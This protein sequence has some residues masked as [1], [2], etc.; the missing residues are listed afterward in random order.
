VNARSVVGRFLEHARVIAFRRGGEWEVWCGS[1]DGMPRSFE[2]RFELM[3]PVADPRARDH[4]LRELRSQLQDDVNAFE[5]GASGSEEPR[6]GGA[7]DCQRMPRHD[8]GPAAQAPEAA[9][10]PP[11]QLPE[12]APPLG[13]VGQ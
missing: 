9:G 6:W 12:L 13:A 4:V 10:R 11:E 8:R 5:L 2:R 7:H 3:F 1:A